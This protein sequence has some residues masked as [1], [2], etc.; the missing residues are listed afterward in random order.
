MKEKN[1]IALYNLN[2]M[3]RIICE[4]FGLGVKTLTM[5]S[6]ELDK[7]ALAEMKKII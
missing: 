3:I 6:W 4:M 1:E 5:A 7:T 2:V